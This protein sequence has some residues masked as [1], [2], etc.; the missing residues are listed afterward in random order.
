MKNE[1]LPTCAARTH[2]GNVRAVNEDRWAISTDHAAQK[3]GLYVVAD[4]VGGHMAGGVAAELALRT[5]V[6]AFE[7]IDNTSQAHEIDG[8]VQQLTNWIALA[9]NA[10]VTAQ[11]QKSEYAIMGT[12]V[13]VAILFKSK[14]IVANVGDSRCYLLHHSVLQ[15]LSVDHSW[16]AEQLRNG[17][18]S[19]KEAKSSLNR[20]ILARALGSPDNATPDISIHD[21]HDGDRILLCSDGLWGML[22]EQQIAILLPKGNPDQAAEALLNAALVA[23][24]EDNITVMVVGDLPDLSTHQQT[25]TSMSEN[26][27]DSGN[28]SSISAHP[29][30]SITHGLS[31]AP[32]RLIYFIS[33]FILL[34]FSLSAALWG[35]NFIKNVGEGG[36]LGQIFGTNLFIAPILGTPS[37]LAKNSTVVV[38]PG[39]NWAKISPVPTTPLP[40]TLPTLTQT[41][42]KPTATATV[43]PTLATR[44]NTPVPVAT[45]T[46]TLTTNITT[47]ATPIV[48]ILATI[49]PSGGGTPRPALTSTPQ[50][51]ATSLSSPTVSAASSQILAGARLCQASAV[52]DGSC[53]KNSSLTREFTIQDNEVY[54]Y[55]QSPLPKGTL[56]KVQW[57]RNGKQLGTIDICVLDDIPC[58]NFDTTANYVRLRIKD[59]QG[60]KLGIYGY[61]IYLS[62][63]LVIEGDFVIR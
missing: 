29:R 24:G 39:D 25:A 59:I 46:L 8:L 10:I 20:N 42:D 43:T 51:A 11:K 12:T 2:T 62:D 26:N 23:G 57:L 52:L 37:E 19:A 49:T 56:L 35:G 7:A 21:W 60:D 63:R 33:T 16:V 5:I 32:K 38:I 41:P 61:K 47:T 45:S 17:V 28:R 55:W 31:K 27:L 14:L 48:A 13:V 3:G 4:G 15:Q 44:I 22:K 53:F 54:L 36:I 9:Q 30:K 50:V 40:L 1:Y 18:I 58:K 34:C 6:D